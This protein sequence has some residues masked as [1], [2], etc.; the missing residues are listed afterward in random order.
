ME[1]N[2][3]Q[4]SEGFKKETV[5]YSFPSEK[6]VKE[7]AQDLG[8]SDSNLRHWCTQYRKRGEFAFPGHGK[9]NLTPQEAENRRLKKE[10]IDI[11]I[12]HDILNVAFAIFKKKRYY[13]MFI[14]KTHQ[15]I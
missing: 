12:E 10:L 7:V 2:K 3:R 9:E 1:A 8:I 14:L 4:D 5:G 15:R 11:Q 6:P 13:Y